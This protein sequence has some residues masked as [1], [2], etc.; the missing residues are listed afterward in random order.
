[1]AKTGKHR[2]KF[3]K[4]NGEV[5]TL[6]G[7]QALIDAI[8]KDQEL[9]DLYNN[10]QFEATTLEG[11]GLDLKVE[12]KKI[13]VLRNTL[14]EVDTTEKKTTTEQ[15]DPDVAYEQA[16]PQESKKEDD[17]FEVIEDQRPGPGQEVK[18]KQPKVGT[19]KVDYYSTEGFFGT[20]NQNESIF[21]ERIKQIDRE[22]VDKMIDESIAE[23]MEIIQK[24]DPAK[25]EKLEEYEKELE[26][27]Q[28]EKDAMT[29]EVEG[30]DDL[31]N[32]NVKVQK[33]K[34]RD[35][36]N[37]RI[38]YL[39]TKQNELLSGVRERIGES[40]RYD[41]FEQ[42]NKLVKKLI[43]RLGLKEEFDLDVAETGE[44]YLEKYRKDLQNQ[45]KLLDDLLNKE[46]IDATQKT[47]AE[48]ARKDIQREL[49]SL[50]DVPNKKTGKLEKSAA[51][52]ELMEGSHGN[53]TFDGKRALINTQA[54]ISAKGGNLNV[55]AHEFLHKLL[56][57]T[58]QKNPAIRLA[59]G[60]AL[61]KEI[62][63]IDPEGVESSKFRERLLSYLNKH[64]KSEK[65]LLDQINNKVTQMNDARQKGNEELREKLNQ[66]RLEL[67]SK[68]NP[69]QAE[70]V[71]TLFSDAVY[72]NEISY[73][74][75]FFTKLG[76]M[77]RRI[78][79]HFG[80]TAK[81]RNGRDVW[82]YIRDYNN[83][84]ETGRGI[85]ALAK[86]ARE[87]IEI[88]GELLRSVIIEEQ[89]FVDPTGRGRTAQEV[90]EQDMSLVFSKASA[91]EVNRIYKEKGKEGAFEI[92]ELYKGMANDIYER[93]VLQLPSDLQTWIKQQDNFKEDL[94]NG[95]LF[96]SYGF[97]NKGTKN[98]SVVG[99][100]QN[101]FETSR[102]AYGN[103]AAYI[104]TFLSR[105]AIQEF[106][107]NLPQESK[108]PEE[109]GP[110]PVKKQKVKREKKIALEVLGSSS[111]HTSVRDIVR[112]S[113]LKLPE[114]PTYK[115]V[116]KLLTSHDG[117]KKSQ[118]VPTGELFA[119]LE[120]ITVDLFGDANMA[121]RLV[122]EVDF[123]T[124]QRT[125]IQDYI[126]KNYAELITYV[127]P[128]GTSQEGKATGAANT[129]L[130]VLYTEGARTKTGP[131]LKEQRKLHINPDFLLEQAGMVKGQPTI[132]TTKV[133]PFLRSMLIQIG[134]MSSNQAIRQEKEVL[135]LSELQVIRLKDGKPFLSFSQSASNINAIIPKR[136]EG[137]LAAI[138]TINDMLKGLKILDN[139]NPED[140][141]TMETFITGTLSK[142]LPWE[143]INAASFGVGTSGNNQFFTADFFETKINAKG[144]V[145]LDKTKLIKAGTRK[146]VQNKVKEYQKQNPLKLSK[147]QIAQVKLAITSKRGYGES[148][149]Y[150]RNNF[151]SEE[152]Q[153]KIKNHDAGVKII[154]T[155]FQNIIKENPSHLPAVAAIFKSQSYSTDHFLRQ[156]AIPKG[157]EIGIGINNT[158]SEHT[159][160]AGKMSELLF[161]AIVRGE[162]NN[163][164]PFVKENYY[165]VGLTKETNIKID[166]LYKQ[167][168]PQEYINVFNNRLKE[169]YSNLPDPII[170]YAH[171]G[172]NLSNIILNNGESLPFKYGLD[173]KGKKLSDG[174]K[175]SIN[176]R[177]RDH[178]Y[179]NY[180]T[181]QNKEYV[182]RTL[183]LQNS[184]GNNKNKIVDIAVSN[185]RSNYRN[186]KGMSTFDFDETLIIDGK[187]FIIATKGKET[188]K[189]SSAAWPI[190]GPE[191]AKQGFK[192][193]F[194]DFVNVRGGVDGP[195]LQKM[196]N[197]IKKFGAKNVF[198]LTARPPEAA[199]A[200]H[201]WLKSKN[202]NIS[203]N[204]ITGLGN[205][206]GEAKAEWMLEKFAEG[207]N[208]MYFVDDALSNVKAVKEVLDQLDV[209][210]K[211]VQAKVQFSKRASEEFNRILQISTGIQSVIKFS[212]AQAK[213][214]GKKRCKFTGLIPP[215][216]Q[217]F[218]GLLYA[219][220]PP[221]KK[222][223]EAMKFFKATLIDPFARGINELNTA[224]QK[225][226][227]SYG[228]LLKA[229][230][231]IKSKLKKDIGKTGFTY[232]QAVRVYLWNKSG[233]EIPGL[234][235]RDLKSLV[236]VVK[237]D[238]VL[239]AFSDA[240]GSVS[241]RNEGY[242]EPSEY[243]LIESIESDLF[244]DGSVGDA[245][246]KYLA[247]WQ[248]NVD[249]I[250]SKDNLNKIQAIYGNKFLEALKDILF[251][252][253]T[254]L[255]RRQGSNRLLNGYYNW[256]NGSVGAIMFFNIRSAVLQTISAVNYVNWSDNNP[257]MAAAAFANQKQFWADF[258]Y[259]FNSDYLKQ[260]RAGNRRGVNEQELSRVVAGKG[261]AEQ[262]KAVIRYLLK[263][264]FLPTQIAD[265]FAIAS[266]GATFYRNRIKSYLKKGM[267]QQEA[268]ERAFLDFQET[269]EVAQQSAR[270]DLISQQQA[271]PLGRLILAFA[272]T[273]MQYGRIIDKGFRDIVSRRGD[274][275]TN[276]SKVIYY[277]FIQSV[278]F[279][280][281][282]S[283]IFAAM[284][285][286][287]DDKLRKNKIDRMLN[288][289]V[290]GWL[291][292]FGY[293]GK[294]INALKNTTMEYLKQDAKDTDD[295]FMTKSDHAYTLLSAVNFS[296]PIGSKL[297]KIY[298]SIQTRKFNREL[299]FERGFTLDNP[300]WSAVGNI[301][302]GVTNIPLGRL[303]NKL[304]NIDNA[305][306][307]RNE[308]YQR[309]ALLLGWNTWD[310]GIRDQDI[311]ALGESI[312]ERKKQEKKME[313]KK[314]KAEKEKEKLRE[315]YPDK[316]DKEIQQTV[317]IEDK[318]KEVFDLKKR[319]QVK[320][321]EQLKLNPENYKLEQDRVDIIMEKYNEN[322]NSI[323]K[324][325]KD[326][327]N[328][329]PTKEEQRSIELF[330]MNKKEQV[331]MLMQLGLSSKQIKKL[332]YEKDRVNKI[333][334]LQN[335]KKS[336]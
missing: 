76:D 305:L 22:M 80:V 9:L 194:T 309:I 257:L 208:D 266:G 74:E 116:K 166:K 229:F 319:E 75:T 149:W 283:A 104:N 7:R 282:Q 334:E 252:M 120:K 310:L 103:L 262:A 57:A 94:I 175:A 73:N 26:A 25:K 18:F 65:A 140:I 215:S 109:T 207:Y 307:S 226:M 292:T 273:P 41:V 285:D 289:I 276:V 211:V 4:K 239:Q 54:S 50:K 177:I 59:V 99:M 279:T 156:I 60:K 332:K 271:N 67:E 250:F 136:N 91:D 31:S 235:K 198:V 278:I 122:R 185:V 183:S 318:I 32:E 138:N 237:L 193:D 258:V 170:R 101:E 24:L 143:F 135:K 107:D 195:L 154:L 253:K 2:F 98:R 179:N 265:S 224:R 272:N 56:L 48:N 87:G 246:A 10:D 245:R 264:G 274:T 53:V 206:T 79:R 164:L 268:E 96:A 93:Y 214:R 204:N 216:A 78:F 176:A 130:G 191:L 129:K 20:K 113:G 331:N 70:E 231:D 308:T 169:G 181:S 16:Y 281:L 35:S 327:K 89:A 212:D 188:I 85:K 111:T 256:V 280:S 63:K 100:V 186:P 202:I 296:P 178:V 290:D 316:T 71:L 155:A 14:P 234:S 243:W 81:W 299:M 295:N 29:Y 171:S 284:G 236:D 286:E 190:Q 203:I 304:L 300:A 132:K 33:R 72:Y 261:P 326:I 298:Q 58:L 302:E 259:L 263:I 254:G 126:R 21:D 160:P 306:D 37:R 172:I 105:R 201:G 118:R 288:G 151:T 123:T 39:K 69:N 294:A 23:E 55:A 77:L 241:K 162:V 187:N 325:L 163:V 220:L 287:D 270:P 38:T 168:F 28:Q 242:T 233:F 267:S 36:I 34:N 47:N 315:K 83:T 147:E 112:I 68:L 40:K 313:K 173:A 222:G 174:Q 153:E 17:T 61:H 323:N 95:M 150:N 64:V 102:Q 44:E 192:F 255:N 210:S 197:Q 146:P 248:E 249:E 227:E 205:S 297:R 314:E 5:V 42:R 128:E 333:I 238:P 213:L 230:P 180:K 196:R 117:A 3:K 200:I 121:L 301:I 13:E 92:A 275:K 30:V 330:D 291:T 119:V 145:V 49:E 303:S 232:D 219:F 335:K 320:I 329:K 131:G 223:E 228:A 142:Y 322:P 152:Y 251:R 82:N 209:K 127:I 217:D 84:I 240:L 199:A 133:D 139:N 157:K 90:G 15:V 182:E 114:K 293:G 51:A 27:L 12:K 167:G 106:K 218:Q 134:V 108:L 324:M 141:Q 46:D 165:Q 221:G 110:E 8:N 269:T 225:S 86:E 115:D 97:I 321:I 317:L 52:I 159:F 336:K 184:L 312:K 328:Y 158:Y 244:S 247:E 19:K 11:V 88:E 148:G 311:V 277:G 260:R 124:K 62:I 125:A 66:E 1:M 144:K 43:E 189:I 161:Q 137:D 6:E 45:S